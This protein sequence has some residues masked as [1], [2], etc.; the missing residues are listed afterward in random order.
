MTINTLRHITNHHRYTFWYLGITVS[1]LCA[2]SST[3]S[4]AITPTSEII[5][6][7]TPTLTILPS[8]I[9]LA[10][11]TDT[12]TLVPVFTPILA[13]TATTVPFPTE[14]TR[15]LAYYWR[16]WPIVPKLSPKAKEILL[17]AKQNSS[18]DIKSLGKVGDCQMAS[19]TFLGGYVREQYPIPPGLEKTIL[20]FSESMVND[21]VTSYAGLG[22]NS[23][24][25]PMFAFAAGYKEC[26]PKETPLSCELR[27]ARPVVVMI[28]LGTNWKPNAEVSFEK[29]MRTI[30]DQ[31]LESGALPILSTKADNVELDWKL[32][33]AIAQIAYDYEL[34]LVNVWRS[35]QDLPNHGLLSPPKQ[36]YLTPDGWMRRDRKSVV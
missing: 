32:N 13:S 1:V 6:A 34:P 30:V 8:S 11:E 29:H 22:V 27:V 9:A 31:V 26:D 7:N 3:A 12:S 36:V 24:L 10:T 28:G 16:N 25:N 14:D 2:C 35:V 21:S 33:L 4:R 5:A 20:W 18:I 19:D 17:R 23:V 15:L